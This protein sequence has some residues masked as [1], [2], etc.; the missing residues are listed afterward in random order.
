MAFTMITVTRTYKTPASYAAQGVVRF[1]PSNPMVN[2]TTTIAAPEWATLNKNGVLS[3][4]LAANNDPSTT[5]VGTT[6]RV[7]EILTGQDNRI[8]DVVIPYN[9][10]SATVDLSTLT[11]AITTTPAV[12]YVSS[13]NG[14]SGAVT[15]AAATDATT[16]V[17]GIARILGGTADA[18]TVP[19][20]SL[21]G[22]DA[23]LT[24]LAALGDGFPSRTA[25]TWAARS[26]AQLLSD[27]GAQPSSTLLTRIAAAAVTVTFAASIT[28]DASQSCVFNV[29]AT[30][31]L[32]LA[33]I[34]NGIDG[35]S[36]NIRVTASGGTRVLT[37]TGIYAVTVTSGSLWSGWFRYDGSGGWQL[38]S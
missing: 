15:I 33:D 22:V 10:P 9:A 4:V 12:Q 8:Y 21:T 32:T 20:S 28:P 29:T 13:V 27:I 16:S 37:I 14:Q 19:W 38:A 25:G 11:P 31:N 1:T 18:P 2:G 6:Y 30:G 7:Q 26:A 24:G 3:I 36:V 34:S 35:Q 17:K 5:P 23:D